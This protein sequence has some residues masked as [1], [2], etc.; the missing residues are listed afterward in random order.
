MEKYTGPKPTPTRPKYTDAESN[1]TAVGRPRGAC[2]HA[3]E[4]VQQPQGPPEFRSEQFR[5]AKQIL[6]R[7]SKKGIQSTGRPHRRRPTAAATD[8][9]GQTVS[10]LGRSGRQLPAGERK[11]KATRY[12]PVWGL[13]QNSENGKSEESNAEFHPPAEP[14]VSFLDPTSYHLGRLANEK[15][16]VWVEDGVISMLIFL[17]PSISQYPLWFSERP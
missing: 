13:S 5:R 6:I 7:K 11:Q 1:S 10:W 15:S 2:H 9:E 14:G 16:E 12:V 8:D 3:H 4:D 17:F